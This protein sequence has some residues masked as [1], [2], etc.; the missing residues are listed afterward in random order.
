MAIS[1]HGIVASGTAVSGDD[2]IDLFFDTL[3]PR[4]TDVES[5][6]L[7][8]LSESTGLDSALAIY[9]VSVVQDNA[10]VQPCYSDLY[11]PG[12]LYQSIEGAG[13]IL[14]RDLSASPA[15]H[16]LNQDLTW[17]VILHDI[18]IGDK[19]TIK[20]ESGASLAWGRAIALRYD[21]V[22][23]YPVPFPHDLFGDGLYKWMNGKSWGWNRFWSLYGGNSALCHAGYPDN[24]EFLEN[25]PFA[26]PGDKPWHYAA[27]GAA[28]FGIATA[29][30]FWNSGVTSYT[31]ASSGI[32]DQYFLDGPDTISRHIGN[33]D[34]TAALSDFPPPNWAGCTNALPNFLSNESFVVNGIALIP[35]LG[36]PYL[37]PEVCGRGVI[38]S[39]EFKNTKPE[40]A[41]PSGATAGSTVGGVILHDAIKSTQGNPGAA[42]AGGGGRQLHVGVKFKSGDPKTDTG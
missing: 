28:T 11:G 3:V 35:G 23:Q 22:L 16:A 18:H 24:S 29:L 25:L 9:G 30:F 39:K 1:F 15:F 32:V 13:A 37:N 5:T 2:H 26:G 34:L 14:A 10:P 42:S 20:Y 36:P 12:N 19:L 31:P 40:E 38:I 27:G 17:G 41:T 7:L 33:L 8:V 4:S 6:N 21:G